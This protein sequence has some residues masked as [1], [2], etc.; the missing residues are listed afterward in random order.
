MSLQIL[1]MF[2]NIYRRRHREVERVLVLAGDDPKQQ[3]TLQ[4]VLAGLFIITKYDKGKTDQI[5]PLFTLVLPP[6]CLLC[7]V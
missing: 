4:P 5:I 6:M 7:L 2:V 1:C 3:R